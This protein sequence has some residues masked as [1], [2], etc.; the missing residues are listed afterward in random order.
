[1]CGKIIGYQQG[2]PDAFFPYIRQ[3]QTTTDSHYVEGISL[4]HGTSPRK[5]IWTFAVALHEYNSWTMYVPVLT[6]ETLHLL[7]FP[8]LWEMTT[9]VTQ[10]VRITTSSSS[11][12]MIFSGM[13]L[14]V[15]HTTPA[16]PGTLYLGS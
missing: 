8:T 11:M 6:H 12:E 1:M 4:T 16:V 13:V 9:S 14:D 5:H 3:G 10:A 15:V 2:T 7:Q